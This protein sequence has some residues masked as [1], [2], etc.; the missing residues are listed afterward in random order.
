[1]ARVTINQYSARRVLGK[2]NGAPK[3]F[4]NAIQEELQEASD[5]VA[6]EWSDA[7]PNGRGGSYNAEM[8]NIQAAVTQPR[9][10]GFFIRMGWLDGGPPAADGRSTWFIYHDTGYHFYGTGH[11]VGGLGQFLKRQS[12]LMDEIEQV[13]WNV[14]DR[15]TA[16]FKG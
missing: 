13:K 3:E 11:W 16:Y 4:L 10:G 6:E 1:M 9:R 14:Q 12:Q 2:I 15:M 7:I 8:K 5:K